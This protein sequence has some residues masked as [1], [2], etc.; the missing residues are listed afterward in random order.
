MHVDYIEP[1]SGQENCCKVNL[2]LRELD[3]FALISIFINELILRANNKTM[4][5][6]LPPEKEQSYSPR[7]WFIIT[8]IIVIITHEKHILKI[9]QIIQTVYANLYHNIYVFI[10]LY[11]FLLRQFE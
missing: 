8:I 5:I 11:P 10:C 1:V 2:T 9:N 3:L 6:I 4:T 7:A